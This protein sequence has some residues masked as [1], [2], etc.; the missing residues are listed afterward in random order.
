MTSSPLSS[1]A[2]AP[3]RLSLANKLAFGAGDMG[4]G[5]TANLVVFSFLAFL[6]N[7]AG[8][9]PG[10]ASLILVVGKIWDAINDPLVGF[11]SD[12]TRSRWGRRHIWML[13]GS[14]PFGLSFTLLWVVPGAET[15]ENLKFAYYLVVSILF[16]TT[17]TTVNLPYAAMTPELTQNYDERTSLN[18]FRLAFSLTGAILGLVLGAVMAQVIPDDP[19][20]QFFVLGVICATISVFPIYWCVWGTRS[21]VK[22]GEAALQVEDDSNSSMPFKQQVKILLG[23]RPYLFVIGIYL[24]SWLALQVTATI[25][26]FFVVNWMQLDSFFLVAL[27][28]QGA[29]IPLLFVCSAISQKLGKRGLYGLGMVL[30]IGIQS[31]LF[32]IQPG[33]TTL[34]YVLALAAS[35]GV[36]TAYVVP[37]SM[38]PDVIELDE[39]RTGQRREGIF[40]SFMTLLQKIG[41]ALGIF[42]VGQALEIAGFVS[43]IPGEPPPPQPDSALLAIRVAI[44]PLPTLCLLIGL[45][46]VYF[47]PLTRDVHAD[48]LLK[49]SERKRQAALD[50]IREAEGTSES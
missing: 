6:T 33:Q 40:Y 14:I 39:L 4:T 43:A 37:W 18:S 21:K 29:A 1:E 3:R 31:S 46:L 13:A 8:L 36:A 11:L 7:V 12:R 26:P 38:L 50:E 30:W 48:I 35:F 49:L 22:T 45:V 34:L 19:R 5:L 25:I 41:L 32:F 16:F 9:S 27:A 28:V 24:T 15:P 17:Y 20:R 42:L 23:N 47:Y 2:I 10:K 44:G